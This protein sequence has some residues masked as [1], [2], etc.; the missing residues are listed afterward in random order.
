M[1]YNQKDDKELAKILVQI[2]EKLIESN[3]AVY[4]TINKAARALNTFIGYHTNRK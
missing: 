4:P 2:K 3:M 1:R